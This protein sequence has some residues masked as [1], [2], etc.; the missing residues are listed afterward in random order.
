MDTIFIIINP[1]N[2][3][4]RKSVWILIIKYAFFF[5]QTHI[6]RDSTKPLINILTLCNDG[7]FS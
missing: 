4:H 2:Q 3:Y 6:E 5:V 7:N 1:K